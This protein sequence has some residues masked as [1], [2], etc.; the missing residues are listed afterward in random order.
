M[1][2]IGHAYLSGES[3]KALLINF[4][5]DL[6]PLNY[7]NQLEGE[8]LKGLRIHYAIDEFTDQH[9][10]VREMRQNLFESYSHYSRVI[11]DILLDHYL[12]THWK[13]LDNSQDLSTYLATI[14]K[15]LLKQKDQL[16][17]NA[18]NVLDLLID[19]D[20]MGRYGSITGIKESLWEFS[21][22]TEGSLVLRDS[23]VEFIA[24]YHEWQKGYLPFMQEL[25]AHLRS[26]Y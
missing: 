25:Q 11:V 17:L 10:Y 16:P 8:Y 7:K 26:L 14:K 6:L 4:T 12:I 1:N 5:A 15:D 21:H 23:Y 22:R 2:F 18:Q 3:E 24:Y 20:W 9:P 19:K 13:Q